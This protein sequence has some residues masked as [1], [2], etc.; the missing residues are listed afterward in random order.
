M[1]S[2]IPK[3]YTHIHKEIASNF[4]HT[5][6]NEV[7]EQAKHEKVIADYPAYNFLGYVW[8]DGK[9]FNCE[10]WQYKEPVEIIKAPT[11]EEIMG[12]ASDKYGVQ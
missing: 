10:I 6:I 7:V 4:D 9:Q 11:I 3:N 12:T 2:K 8:W 1:M 5:V